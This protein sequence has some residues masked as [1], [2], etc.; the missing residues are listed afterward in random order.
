MLKD[1]PIL[2][3]ALGQTLVWAGLYYVFPA[4]VL[5]WEATLGFTKPQLSLAIATALLCSALAAP[6][7]GRLI[8]QARGPAVMPVAAIIAGVLLIALSQITALWQFYLIW[9]CMGFAMS[10]CL[11]EACFAVI[12]RARGAK[13]RDPIIWV[14]LW[15][16]LA[17]TL[18]FP[19]AYA[20]TTEFGWRVTVVVFGLAV[21]VAAAPLLA[22]GA[23]RLERDSLPDRQ[24]K[25]HPDHAVLR[26]R[27]CWFL[28]AALGLV[29]LVQ[30][31]VIQHVL[32]IFESFQ[33]A[34][35]DAVIAASLI[36]PM[37]VAGRVAL[38]WAG[39]YV[40][41]SRVAAGAILA[42]TAA[43]LLL[44]AT[45]GKAL[46]LFI[47]L[48]GAAYGTVSVIRPLIA[49]HVLGQQN[50]GAKSGALAMPYLIGFAVAP[51]IGALIWGQVGYS[52]MLVIMAGLAALAGLLFARAFST[53]TPR[54]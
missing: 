2:A 9:A 4:L 36:G 42:L 53:A 47:L 3:L 20:L 41:L 50:F 1:P 32:P 16:G 39:P 30:S 45:A 33:I 44:P 17:S 40:T 23:A 14:T 51:Y 18:S 54:A 25:A 52:G 22:W 37:Q 28:A 27:A 15:A 26:T 49:R 6:V 31:A 35:K 11:Y 21:I 19:S 12:T 8:D 7:A 29:A 5:Q 46:P 48:F 10:G 13:A 34:P 24:I 38:M 43:L